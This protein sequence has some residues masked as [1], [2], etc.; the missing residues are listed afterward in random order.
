MKEHK[1]EKDGILVIGP[2]TEAIHNTLQ[3]IRDKVS[4]KDFACICYNAYDFL[5]TQSH[6]QYRHKLNY[7]YDITDEEVKKIGSTFSRTIKRVYGEKRT[8]KL[9]S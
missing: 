4:I 9:L 1:F 6:L 8:S 2:F 3:E 7:Y 5:S